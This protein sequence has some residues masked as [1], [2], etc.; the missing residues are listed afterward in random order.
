MDTKAQAQKGFKTFIITLLVSL[1]VFSAIY[2]VVNSSTEDSMDTVVQPTNERSQQQ[3]L[4]APTNN[5]NSNEEAEVAA[6]SVKNVAMGESKTESPF[7]ELAEAK[8][9][10][11]IGGAPIQERAVLAG[12]DGPETSQATVPDT[13]LFG[14]TF[15]IIF[16]A[17]ALSIAAYLIFAGPRKLALSSFE[18]KVRNKL[19]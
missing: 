18:K 13:G 12:A 16:S 17:T 1:V 19:N 6:A 5:A 4:R 8:T 3:Q 7:E 11:R 14:P 15:G 10:T 9:P 2:Y